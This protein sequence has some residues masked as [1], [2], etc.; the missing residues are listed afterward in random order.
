MQQLAQHLPQLPAFDAR[1]SLA[2]LQESIKSMPKAKAR[3]L[4][5]FSVAELGMLATSE[6]QLLCEIFDV[7]T[8]TGE[9]PTCL[10][11]AY[12]TL[13]NKT[14]TPAGPQDTRPITV[15][16]TLFRLWSR[17]HARKVF[18]SILE[19]LPQNLYGSVPGKGIMDAA[20][21]LQSRLEE[22]LT[23][24]SPRCG[25]TCDLSKCYNTIPREFVKLLALKAGWPT[26][27]IDSKVDY[28][29]MFQRCFKLHDGVFAP[30]TSAI[31]V[32]EGDT[33][34]VPIMIMVTWA[35]TR[36]VETTDCEMPSYLDNWIIMAQAPETLQPAP[37]LV[38]WA[39]DGLGLIL[40]G[41]K[42]KAFA[43][44]STDR[45]TLRKMKLD[46]FSLTTT[47]VMHELGTSFKVTHQPTADT[48]Q[49]RYHACDLKFQRLQSMGW[50]AVRKCQVLQRVLCPALF[51]GVELAST[52]PTFLSM[53]RAWFSSV[54]FG[55]HHDRNHF[56]APLVGGEIPYEPF[57]LVF[58]QRV[59]AIRRVFHR[60][61]ATAVR[62]WN[63]ACLRQNSYIPF[64]YFFHMLTQVGWRENPDM[65]F[66]DGNTIWHVGFANIELTV[67][68]IWDAWFGYISRKL[69]DNP[70]LQ[71][72]DV[73]DSRLSCK[74]RSRGYAE[75]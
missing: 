50:S 13:L 7:F 18:A 60:Q 10:L 45:A 4:D 57:L 52:S 35:V 51:Y 43:T 26:Q 56:L 5:G 53:V 23:Q 49:K 72:L 6:Q 68:S 61:P 27:L 74:V 28:L 31:G 34:S 67:S 29:A 69:G 66:G 48:L 37:D 73:V 17:V 64:R 30:T 32:P 16:P 71:G 11:Q 65:L 15:L 55:K 44:T 8:F 33:L 75:A 62:R 47:A 25:V 41:D 12:V 42:T 54:V 70:E 38:K 14:A 59:K 21:E 24:G 36:A 1:V 19:W 9:W 3:G 39:T 40:K 2:E 20:M 46:G 63:F 22:S 58:K